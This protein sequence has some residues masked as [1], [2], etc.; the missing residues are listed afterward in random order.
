MTTPFVDTPCLFCKILAGE[1]P[2]RVVYETEKILAFEDLYPQ[3]PIHV[4]IIS[5][6]HTPSHLE[7]EDPTLYEDLLQGAKALAQRFAIQDYRLVMNNGAGA[8]QSVFHMHL[9]LMAGRSFSWP[10][11]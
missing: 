9:H 3:A 1:I 4:L 7:T 11:G 2:A 5:K 10:A 6:T 8:G